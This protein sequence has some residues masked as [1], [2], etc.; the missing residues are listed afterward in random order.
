MACDGVWCGECYT[1]HPK[2]RF[3]QFIPHGELGFEWCQPEDATHYCC[4]HDGNYLVTIFQCDC[5]IFLN[6]TNR[7]PLAH[8]LRDDLLMCCIC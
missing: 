4:G 2:D 6:L 7:V 3:Y 8:L 1:K 5:C